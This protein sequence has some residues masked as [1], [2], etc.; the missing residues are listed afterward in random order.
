MVAPI[1]GAKSQTTLP[2]KSHNRTTEGAA[3]HKDKAPLRH[4]LDTTPIMDSLD[5]AHHRHPQVTALLRHPKITTLLRHLKDTLHQRHPQVTALLRHLKDTLHHRHPQVTALLRHPKITTL[6]RHLKDMLH[7]RHPHVTALL[8]NPQDH[9][10]LPFLTTSQT[11]AVLIMKEG[12]KTPPMVALTKVAM[13]Q[14]ILPAV[15]HNRTTE[16]TAN[17]LHPKTMAIPTVDDSPIVLR[18]ATITV[19]GRREPPRTT[20]PL[21]PVTGTNGEH[22]D[23]CKK[24]CLDLSRERSIKTD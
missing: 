24:S 15:N 14:T 23:A 5:T 2:T 20:S 6:L 11:M 4:P 16:V 19:D 18:I 7:H 17:H 9:M 1:R 22:D 21:T 10:H 12:P 3:N 13:G 8:R